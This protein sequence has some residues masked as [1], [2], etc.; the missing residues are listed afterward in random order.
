MH[1]IGRSRLGYFQVP[2]VKRKSAPNFVNI[3]I[4]RLGIEVSMKYPGDM[5]RYLQGCTSNYK[6]E[7]VYLENLNCKFNLL[8]ASEG[9]KLQIASSSFVSGVQQ[10]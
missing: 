2:F 3:F 7:I 9:S 5:T 10:A 1:A 8:I 6:K 4:F